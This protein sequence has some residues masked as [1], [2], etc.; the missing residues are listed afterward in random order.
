MKN[1]SD[2]KELAIIFYD[3]YY[4]CMKYNDEKML[5][6]IEKKNKNYKKEIDCGMYFNGYKFFIEKYINDR[7]RKI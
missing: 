7:N 1:N 5:S 2:D 3:F 6:K 4:I